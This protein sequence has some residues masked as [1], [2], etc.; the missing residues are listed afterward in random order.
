MTSSN[1]IQP[2]YI[3]PAN[4]LAVVGAP[5]RWCRDHAIAYGVAVHQVGRRQLI[6]AAEFQSAL[7]ARN[8]GKTQPRIGGEPLGLKRLGVRRER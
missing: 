5:W 2:L 3:G 1:E 4:A 7:R 8:K 6:D